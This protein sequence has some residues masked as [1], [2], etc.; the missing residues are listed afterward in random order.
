VFQ[1]TTHPATEPNP[2]VPPLNLN[3]YCATAGDVNGDG[4]PDILVATGAIAQLN[5]QSLVNRIYINVFDLATQKRRLLDKTFGEDAIPNTADDRLPFDLD[6]SYDVRLAD[7]D[8][9]GDLDAFVSN[10]TT[11]EPAF[12]N[13]SGAQNRFYRNED[14]DGDGVGD[15]FFTDVTNLWDPGILNLGPFVATPAGLFDPDAANPFTTGTFD[16]STHSDVA[17]IDGDGDI[18]IIV[19]N[20]NWFVDNN[21]TRG[22]N[23]LEAPSSGPVPIP[24]LRFSERVLINHVLEPPNSPYMSLSALKGWYAA[25]HPIDRQGNPL[26]GVAT[27]QLFVDETLGQDGLFGGG[28]SRF[29]L[30][31]DENV[32]TSSD[33]LPPLLPDFPTYTNPSV[34]SDDVSDQSRSNAVKIGHW[35]GSNAP[36]FVVFNKRSYVKSGG[37]QLAK[38]P[39]DGDDLVYLNQDL[40][41]QLGSGISDGLDEGIFFVTNYGTEAF[42]SIVS[43]GTTSTAALGIPDGLPGDVT[44]PDEGNVKQ[45]FTDQSSMGVFA[46]F[47]SSGWPQFLSL[48][49]TPGESHGIYTKTTAIS[50]CAGVL[51]GTGGLIPAFAA[52]YY[53]LTPS[54]G[55][56][57][58][59]RR[60]DRV[61]LPKRGRARSACVADLNIDGLPDIIVAHDTTLDTDEVQVGGTPPGYL[62]VYYN[63]DFLNFTVQD[64]LTSAPFLNETADV[65]SWVEP[66]DYDCD[67]DMDLFVGTYGSMEKVIENRQTRPNKPLTLPW[68]NPNPR[69]LPL[70]TDHTVEMLPPYYGLGVAQGQSYPDGY[71]NITLAADLA[72]IDGDGDLDLVFANGGINTSNGDYQV[73]YKNNNYTPFYDSRTGGRLIT[74]RELKPGEHIFTPLGT[75]EKAPITGSS[76]FPV[77]TADEIIGFVVGD[78]DRIP[79]YDARFFDF[80]ADGAADVV[81]T[82]NGALPRFLHNVD[83]SM[84]YN[85]LP[86]PDAKPDGILLDESSSRLLHDYSAG[87]TDKIV[88]R[89]MA[90]GDADGDGH[91]DIFI[92]NGVENLGARNVLLM[93]RQQ[94]GQWGYFQDESWR[95][96]NNGEIYDD[97]T[98]AKFTDIDG[99]GDLDL[100]ITNRPDSA[101]SPILYRYCRLL[102]NQG[103]TFVEITDPAR[104]PLF[105]KLLPAEVVLVGKFFG[106]PQDDAVIGCSDGSVVVL[107][108]DGTGRFTDQTATRVVPTTD[109]PPFPIYGGDVGDIDLDGRLDIVWAV[110][111]QDAPNSNGPRYKIPVLLWLQSPAGQ[112]VDV[113]DSELPILKTQLSPGTSVASVPGQARGVRLGDI[114]GDG[115]LDMIICQAGR[116]DTMPSIGWY[117]AVLLNNAIG[118]NLSHNRFARPLPPSNPFVFSVWPPKGMQG[119]VLDVTIKG[120]NFAGSPQLDFGSG[121]SVVTPAQASADGEYLF[122]QIRVDDSAPIG[123]RKVKVV[124]PTGLAGESAP[125]A[126]KVVPPGT[127]LPTGSDD[128]Q[129]YE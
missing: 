42:L 55:I 108:N 4:Y 94:A 84:P 19:S 26:S 64:A 97:S 29:D 81:F 87:A 126:F 103:G 106:G 15:G 23:T 104:W 65:N 91:P 60:S 36:G 86:D 78:N 40:W 124:S 31:G 74:K 73:V 37:V 11:L 1:G 105:G 127:L 69:D 17:D 89:R 46:D 56:I 62:A 117:N 79:A 111:T 14:I 95:L 22:E 119:Q 98:D 27:T 16:M 5:P 25:T 102:E 121:I 128:W 57:A 45:V 50:Y 129:H 70:F 114:D 75:N 93:N 35:W 49:M 39:W 38:G 54:D 53:N 61:T 92:C 66:I 109:H 82:N 113:S 101:P 71:S 48:N 110:N 44:V 107:R 43:G 20:F 8:L 83:A 10:F 30:A 112:F 6:G 34:P 47:N 77:P 122:A 90:V 99:D 12:A 76:V 67:G 85:A 33:R 63:N 3:I 32:T 88:S 123:G 115:D 28:G 51:R 96:P 21:R 18:D 100:I 125:N 120:K 72:D 2:I 58:T 9:D 59:N 41:S 24:R 52:D 13:L 80:D 7:F 116:G 118:I 68:T